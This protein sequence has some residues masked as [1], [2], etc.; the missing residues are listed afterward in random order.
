[1]AW[2]TRLVAVVPWLL[3]L[4]GFLHT[5][6]FGQEENSEAVSQE[7]SEAE[8]GA[9]P[10]DG[11]PQEET[12]SE[13][14]AGLEDL[15]TYRG[16]ISVRWRGRFADSAH[17][18]DLSMYVR[19]QIN[20]AWNDDTSF[21]LFGRVT[22][23]LDGYQNGR[24]GSTYFNIVD[25][26]DHATNARLYRAHLDVRGK[27]FGAGDA[28]ERVRVGRQEAILGAT[29]L[30]DGMSVTTTKIEDAANLQ[31]TAYGGS[32]VRFFEDSR[33]GD[34]LAGA[35]ARWDVC[36]RVQ[37]EVEYTHID[38]RYRGFRL[39]NGRAASDYARI[40]VTANPI[41]RLE[42]QGRYG[43]L[44]GNTRDIELTSRLQIPEIG[45]DVTGSLLVFTNTQRDHAF[46]YDPYFGI[47]G[48]LQA[49]VQYGLQART[50]ID[51][52]WSFSE[53]FSVRQL[54]DEANEGQFNRE[55][56]RAFVSVMADELPLPDTTISLSGDWYVAQGDDIVG[57][58]LDVSWRPLDDFQA[59]FGTAYYLYRL[60]FFA[61]QERSDVQAY[62]L[63]MQKQLGGGFSVD[64][65]YELEEAEG[66][67]FHGL[68][69]GFTYR[70]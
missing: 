23:D 53:G 32:P 41:D 51:D 16:S 69:L 67:I 55:Y 30:F 10:S 56:G 66:D 3:I 9:E 22:Q 35:M 48:A 38:E 40:S 42:I 4:Q 17:D 43:W 64:A 45:T 28:I 14:S 36:S 59:S 54:T 61:Q 12:T 58:S 57:A 1:M 37:M 62:Y 5:N 70:F 31:F 34:W 26:F 2:K 29:Y 25:T 13:E 49:Y 11:P 7:E 44:E 33:S 21:T 18:N 46:E 24:D 47:L 60:D 8:E 39:A 15:L 19:T 6:V 65:R 50:R 68:Y 27:A 63:R 52:T 20:D